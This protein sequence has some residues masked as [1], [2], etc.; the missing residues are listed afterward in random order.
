V[1]SPD[2]RWLAYAVRG[3]DVRP[4]LR[5]VATDGSSDVLV[6]E[7]PRLS[8]LTGL[9]AY[10]WLG[11]GRIVY[12]T[13]ADGGSALVAIDVDPATARPRG[14]PVVRASYPDVTGIENASRDGRALLYAR[15]HLRLVRYQA[16][17]G[18]GSL[19][20]EPTP[21]QSWDLIGA[22]PDGQAAG[23][24]AGKT[25]V[26]LSK[27]DTGRVELLAI[28][29]DGRPRVLAAFAGLVFDPRITPAG[30]AV[31]YLHVD[32]DAHAISLRRVALAGGAPV[33]VEQLPYRPS[34]PAAY[35]QQLVVQLG[36]GRAPGAPCVLGAT[37]GRQQVFYEV[38]PVRGRGRKL[39]ALDG[40]PPW[41]WD[42]RPDGRRLVIAQQDQ[43]VR[44]LELGAD[45][46]T[47]VLGDPGMM[48]GEAAWIGDADAF[49]I[50]GNRASGKQI[51][52][53]ELREP[54]GPASAPVP[55]W[56]SASEGARMLRVSSDGRAVTFR[57]ASWSGDYW[58][59][60]DP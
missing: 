17:L 15:S 6:V 55:V 46:P 29:S 48:V 9:P 23:Q 26:Y 13:Y 7:D 18:S 45:R 5:A 3:S 57:A 43:A 27:P 34:V 50:A 51:A 54:G 58:L 38:D 42:L 28:G 56:T 16:R 37:E 60:R 52:R 19:A 35:T 1:W 24:A 4:Q 30:D 31:L 44:I 41:P 40:P 2:G 32:D 36:C 12:N 11:D 59:R 21:H 14:P 25:E 53:V 8:P 49:L 47:V 22:T 33:V 39:V 20:V 10:T